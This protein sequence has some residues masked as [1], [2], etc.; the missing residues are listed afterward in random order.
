MM[1]GCVAGLGVIIIALGYALWTHF[2]TPTVEDDFGFSRG[3]TRFTSE[4][5]KVF[6]L[7][8]SWDITTASEVKYDK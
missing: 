4:D 3:G 1:W 2:Y 5:G 6:N 8:T 7:S